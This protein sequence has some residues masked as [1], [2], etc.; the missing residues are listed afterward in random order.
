ML[1]LQGRSL[2]ESSP[3]MG[4]PES[5]TRPRKNQAA[6]R[7]K[8]R[9]RR[10][11]CLLKGCEQRFHPRHARQ[12]YCSAEC[13][14]KAEKWRRWKAQQ[15]YRIS[16]SGKQKRNGRSRRYRERVKSRKLP[17]DEADNEA[18]RVITKARPFNTIT[19]HGRSV[20]IMIASADVIKA[21]LRH[22]MIQ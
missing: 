14:A 20:I 6:G 15:K 18:T 8:R 2:W 22:K 19:Y 5:L 16:D 3:P 10:R 13:R 1:P 7:W 11:L 12:R 9:P 21:P 17:E 4:P